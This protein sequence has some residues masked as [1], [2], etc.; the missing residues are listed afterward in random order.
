ML[1]KDLASPVSTHDLQEWLVPFHCPK[2]ND[3]YQDSEIASKAVAGTHFP[4]KPCSVMSF[5]VRALVKG[6]IGHKMWSSGYMLV[7]YHVMTAVG[8]PKVFYQMELLTK[9]GW[10]THNKNYWN[11]S[12]R[13][14]PI[15][16]LLYLCFLP[17]LPLLFFKFIPSVPDGW[18][19]Q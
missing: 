10:Q 16:S 15:S 12:G 19:G 1:W 14:L 3:R 8:K 6:I 17:I 13:D 5:K 4:F 9:T 18:R 2:G 11:I 7:F